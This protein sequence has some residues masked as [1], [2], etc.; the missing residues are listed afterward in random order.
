MGRLPESFLLSFLAAAPACPFFVASLEWLWLVVAV[1][2]VGGLQ[3]CSFPFLCFPDICI[4]C[5]S[6]N[7]TLEHPLFIGGMCQNCKVGAHPA[8]VIEGAPGPLVERI[9]SP[10]ASLQ[11]GWGR[12]GGGLQGLLWKQRVLIKQTPG[13]PLGFKR[14]TCPYF[15]SFERFFVPLKSTLDLDVGSQHPSPVRSWGR[16][17]DCWGGFCDLRTQEENPEPQQGTKG[18]A[19]SLTFSQASSVLSTAVGQETY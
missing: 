19:F 18:A 15:S 9:S 1:V 5:G 2:V 4:S 12:L 14:L 13:R 8:D 10:L 17:G 7:V 3:P 11:A 16:T 6:L